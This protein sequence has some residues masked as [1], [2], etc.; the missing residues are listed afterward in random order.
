MLAAT[1]AAGQSLHVQVDEPGTLNQKIKPTDKW[2]ATSLIVRGVLNGSDLLYLREMAGRDATGQPTAGRLQRLSLRACRFAAGGVPYYGNSRI[3]A[4]HEHTVPAYA[5]KDC[6]LE[7][8]VLPAEADSVADYALSGTAL[9]H[10]SLSPRCQPGEGVF[11][12]CARLESVKMPRHLKEYMPGDLFKGCTGLLQLVF[13]SVGYVSSAAFDR[14]PTVQNIE[15][16]GSIGHIDGA[17][18]SN[19][20]Q[21]RTVDFFGPICSTGGKTFVSNCPNLERVALRAAVLHTGFGA[22]E[23]CP[24]LAG[25]EITGPI[26]ESDYPESLPPT[27]PQYYG[28][29]SGWDSTFAQCD[30]WVDSALCERPFMQLAATYASA[31]ALKA[32]LALGRKAEA[33]K[34]LAIQVDRKQIYRD[35]L[36]EDSTWAPLRDEPTFAALVERAALRP[37]E[38]RPEPQQPQGATLTNQDEEP[39]NPPEQHEAETDD[40]TYPIE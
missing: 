18:I 40:N 21:L 8:I 25:Y 14:L 27:P 39:A 17:S 2:R 24:R 38:E 9:R 37:A 22:P 12:D 28:A 34:H 33:M 19:C 30:L 5:F 15:F 1:P 35:E 36:L 16:R 31:A 26:I 10:V 20:P 23:R 6:H 11:E 32:A 13:G 29:W 4:G 7:Q 3:A